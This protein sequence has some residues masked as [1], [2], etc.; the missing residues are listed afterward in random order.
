MNNKI[1]LALIL[2]LAGCV[3]GFGILYQTWGG[4]PESKL[5]KTAL[6]DNAKKT[7]SSFDSILGTTWVNQ[8]ILFL[9]FL[10]MTLLYPNL[11]SVL[12]SAALIQI[13]KCVMKI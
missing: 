10:K 8:K 11:G 5:N 12:T 6:L 3:V 1:R 7:N 4:N 2:I 9:K 13:M